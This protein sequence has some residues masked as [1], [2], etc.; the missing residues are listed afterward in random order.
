MTAIGIDE[1]MREGIASLPWQD[2][3]TRKLEMKIESMR[4]EGATKLPTEEA[5]SAEFRVG[6]SAIH[7]T[8]K[9]LQ[10]KGLVHPLRSKGSYLA[11]EELEVE[12][13]KD[14]GYTRN[15]R[16]MNR[17]PRAE[18]LNICICSP[19]GIVAKEMKTGAGSHAWSILFRRY[20]GEIPISITTSFL[21]FGR[22]RGL[23]AALKVNASL[24]ATLES[25]YGV[26]PVRRSSTC[27]AKAADARESRYLLVPLNYPLLRV[28]SLATDQDGRAV[29][30]CETLFRSDMVS[31][32]IDLERGDAAI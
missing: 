30:Y 32:R 7:R 14:T 11:F 5:L 2:E 4:K 3:L 28:D 12:I 17:A 13:S 25:S 18:I 15:F 22:F 21:P 24:Y 26:K 16:R 6:R 10:A 23:S 29:E 31:V 27:R 19:K 1:P 9:K 20:H 8:I